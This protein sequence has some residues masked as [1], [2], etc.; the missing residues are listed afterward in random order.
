M[1]IFQTD[2][3][4][5]TKN[6][7]LT[8]FLESDG[9]KRRF[10]VPH[11]HEQLG[12]AERMNY[13]L[14]DMARTM[15]ADSG[16]PLELW[17]EAIQHA[18]YVRNHCPTV[19]VSDG[20]P[21]GVYHG[22][23]P[24][25][26]HFRVFGAR[27]FY[28]LL[29]H[30]QP[31][32]FSPRGKMGFFVGFPPGIKGYRVYSPDTKKIVI[33]RDVLYWDESFT[34]ESNKANLQLSLPERMQVVERLLVQEA[35]DSGN[36]VGAARDV[37]DVGED[38]GPVGDVGEN[39]RANGEGQ[40]EPAE[41]LGDTPEASATPEPLPAVHPR[42]SARQPT[43]PVLY[44]N[45]VS[46][47]TSRKP[48]TELNLSDSEPEDEA[49]L[50]SFSMAE[51]N[52]AETSSLAVPRSYY[53]AVR[54]G[55]LWE[56]SIQAEQDALTQAG[57]FVKVPR[58]SLAPD[59][60]IV[61]SL[62]IFSNKLD[63]DGNLVKR[64]TRIVADGSTQ[65]KGINYDETYAPVQNRTTTRILLS[66]IAKEDLEADQ[67]DIN[68]AFLNASLKEKVYMEIPAGMR[69]GDDEDM[70]ALLKKSLYGLK[71]APKEW[72]AMYDGWILAYGFQHATADI[73]LYLFVKGKD[74]IWVTIHVDDSIICANSVAAKND[75]KKA[76]G[77]RFKMDDRG[78]IS[79]FLGVQIKRDRQ[80]RLIWLCQSK[81]LR[82]SLERY[83]MV[84]CNPVSTPMDPGSRLDVPTDEDFAACSSF[85]YQNVVG[86]MQYAAQV[87][88]PDIAFATNKLA[89]FNAKWGRAQI[90]AAKHLLRYIK[91]T[92]DLGLC[93][94]LIQDAP[95]VIG[96]VDADY[97]GDL[98][99]RRSTT[100]YVFMVNGDCTS[101]RSKRQP[102][103]AKS[104]TEAEYMASADSA[105]EAV[106]VKRLL[107]DISR[108][109]DGSLPLKND[110]F[111]NICLG[112]HPGNHDRTKHI[113][114]HHHFI[115]EK[116]EAGVLSMTHCPTA[117]N[118][119]DILTKPLPREL[120]MKHRHT[121]G[122]RKFGQV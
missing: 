110:N 84:N 30:Q 107:G 43:P 17:A 74:F 64:K 16:L 35:S 23:I 96:Y 11:A 57:T 108:P 69:S 52:N 102:T 119:A 41:G 31:T 109:V 95:L 26:S 121:L 50:S 5:E 40:E 10:I 25:C 103:V 72:N 28:A 20:V 98:V 49:D 42:R 48:F 66:F 104:T 8:D 88:R 101:W 32:K 89:Q 93:Y 6:R 117:E 38:A 12:V 33:I 21:A 114:I 54:C 53:A 120:F 56:T 59:D 61:K 115:R 47:Q 79:Y 122:L 118:T 113:D 94:G 80:K 7:S 27:V 37:E 73:C 92:V 97:A 62:Y 2:N 116:I 34:A 9:V 100:G 36:T 111:G 63:A 18:A 67:C 105:K 85:P 76:M 71:Q 82:E 99:T 14:C 51:A 39:G 55:N 81:Y 83:N 75:F 91:G 86:T 4:T 70:V 112:D 68:T 15:L 3:G 46:S 45:M 13:T 106:W 60:P 1:Q 58:S 44:G 77:T 22:E 29:K 65:V 87:T 78:P 19:A 24:D 90:A